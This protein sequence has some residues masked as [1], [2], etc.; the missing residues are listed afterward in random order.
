MKNDIC[1]FVNFNN[2]NAISVY[3]G[4]DKLLHCNNFYTAV[5]G[6]IYNEKGERMNV[7]DVYTLYTRYGR[8]V[9]TYLDGTYTVIIIDFNVKKAYVFQ[10]LFGF[11]Q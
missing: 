6:N 4:E 11:N 10:D 7:K 9:N 2:L 8:V 3:D 1:I 5:L